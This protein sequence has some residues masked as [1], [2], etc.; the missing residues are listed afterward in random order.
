[1]GKKKYPFRLYGRH[2]LELISLMS[3]REFNITKAVYCSLTA[4]CNGDIFRIKL[5]PERMN[6]VKEIRKSYLKILILDEVKDKKAIEMMEKIAKGYRSNF[7]KNILR[8][9]LCAPVSVDYFNNAADFLEFEDQASVFSQ[10]RRIADAASFG[11][12]KKARA[13]ARPQISNNL[14]DDKQNIIESNGDIKPPVN[15]E[16]ETSGR[17]VSKDTEDKNNIFKMNPTYEQRIEPVPSSPIEDK[18]DEKNAAVENDIYN[19]ENDISGDAENDTADQDE[20]TDL[21]A[22]LLGL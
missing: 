22:N 1:M 4:F 17:A 6:E 9:Y 21:F 3:T 10:N 5:P 18:N 7:L 14:K 16:H 11:R 12:N 2:D 20:M 8:L 15:P 19:T 13:A